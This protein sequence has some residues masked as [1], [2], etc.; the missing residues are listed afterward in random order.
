MR[1]FKKALFRM[2]GGSN[3]G[4]MMLSLRSSPGEDSGDN[5]C[6]LVLSTN[7][8]VFT[9]SG[10]I[11]ITSG[12]IVYLTDGVTPFDG[13]NKYYLIQTQIAT[14]SDP[15]YICQVDNLGVLGIYSICV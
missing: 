5:N 9:A 13:N 12:D 15:K 3:S 14:E 2:G 8:K 4:A 7:C 6:G 11:V 1:S 10:G